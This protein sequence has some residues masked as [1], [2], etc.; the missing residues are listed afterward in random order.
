MA[1]EFLF[2]ALGEGGMSGQE[3]S[4][5]GQGQE[6]IFGPFKKAAFSPSFFSEEEEKKKRQLRRLIE[7]QAGIRVPASITPTV[8]GLGGLLGSSSR[9]LGGSPG[10]RGFGSLGEGLR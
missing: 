10:F 4:L 9:T 1:F 2:D 6:S 7:T 8:I 3:G 5:L